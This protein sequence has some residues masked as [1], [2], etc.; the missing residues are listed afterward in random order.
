M[1]ILLFGKNGQVGWELERVLPALGTV[2]GLDFH[3]VD[4][5]R[6]ENLR[7][8][9]R[10][11]H[12]DLIVNAAAYT[13][14][15]QAESEPAKAMAV[16]GIAPGILAEEAAA[17]GAGLVHYSTDYV[18]DGTKLAPYTEEDPAAPLNVYGRTKLEGDRAVAGAGAAYLI[19]RTSWVYGARGRNFTQTIRRLARERTELRIVDDQVGNPTWCRSIAEATAQMLSGITNAGGAGFFAEMD[20]CKG[21]YNFSSEG[22]VSWFDFA[23]AILESDPGR[24]QHRVREILPIKTAEYPTAARRP[25]FSVLSKEK[26][27]RV[28]GISAASW[29]DQFAGCMQ[30]LG[31]IHEGHEGDEE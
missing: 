8:V 17:L 10:A 15:D 26:I 2:V 14:V 9:V 1:R 6:P 5:A 25:L 24:S 22:E 7:A 19:L 11:Q 29:R 21:V 20:R 23:R 18:F 28:F 3:E 27:R 4:F 30:A 16:N 13:A 12:P 31:P